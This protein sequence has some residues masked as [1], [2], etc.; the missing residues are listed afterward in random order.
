MWQPWC[1]YHHS[2][3]IDANHHITSR[4][5]CDNA[6]NNAAS[7]GERDIGSADRAT[8]G[9]SHGGYE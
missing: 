4:Q 6:A 2:G 9:C 7:I 1:Y 5:Y 8:A 3:S